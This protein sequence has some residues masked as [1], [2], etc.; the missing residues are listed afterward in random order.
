[1]VL[2]IGTTDDILHFWGIFPVLIERL[3]SSVR[4]EVR[5]VAVPLSI[6]PDILS[7][8]DALVVSKAL[9]R[10]KISTSVQKISSGCASEGSEIKLW[11]SA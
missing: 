10:L 8:P 11:Q 3:K 2:G 1:M 5:E 4:M 6:L 7:G 9:S